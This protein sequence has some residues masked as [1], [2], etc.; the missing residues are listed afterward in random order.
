MSNIPEGYKQTEVGILP[1]DWEV[2][3]LEEVGEALI[4]LTYSPS[5][6]A[7][8]G[9]LV[10]RS[11]NIQNGMLSFGDNVYVKSE[12]PDRIMVRTGDILICV[13]N[14]SR[15]LI[16]KST[17]LDNRA[18]GMTFGAFMS[19][20]RSTYTKYLAHFFKSHIFL[21]QVEQ[22]LG[23]TINQITNASIYSFIAPLPPLPEQHAI[24]EALADADALIAAQ[25][26][27]IAKKQAIK[28]GAMQELLTGRRRLEGFEGVWDI[29]PIGELLKIRHGKNQREVEVSDGTIPILATG[30]QIGVAATPLYSKPSVLIGRK[31]TINKPQYIEK[32]FWTVDTL[33]YSEILGDN[34]AKFLYYVFTN[35]DWMQ[36]NEASG[37]PSLNARTIEAVEIACP[38]PAE[39][40]A[41]AVILSDMDAEIEALEQRL[42]KMRAL[43]QGMMQELL[44][45]R[46]RLI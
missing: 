37:V 36:F 2:K 17:V 32:P 7:S 13:R 8:E 40:H 26:R 30:G 5:D 12:V 3:K 20:F 42:S 9:I 10:L 46:T 34:S 35:I 14:G 28:Q 41:I 18:N 21:S 45:G 23:A 31:G 4:G 6:V 38:L 11:S 27:L 43:K 1:E 25:E 24:A 16:G 39:Q 29:R 19:V 22:H 33:F 44:T 15:D